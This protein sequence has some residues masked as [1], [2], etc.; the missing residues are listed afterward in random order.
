MTDAKNRN[1][2]MQAIDVDELVKQTY[3]AA[4]RRPTRSTW[5]T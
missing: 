2:V 5:P 3:F 1:A 4:A